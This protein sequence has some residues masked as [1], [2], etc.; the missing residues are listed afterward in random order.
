MSYQILTSNYKE[1]M[2]VG[3]ENKHFNLH[4]VAHSSGRRCKAE[5]KSCKAQNEELRK[6]LEIM[7]GQIRARVGFLYSVN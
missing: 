6:T 5:L 3:K 1:S 2:A 4:M 7:E